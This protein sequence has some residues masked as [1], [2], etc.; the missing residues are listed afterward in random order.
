MR[1]VGVLRVQCHWAAVLGDRDS[2]RDAGVAR[3]DVAEQ[4]LEPLD[5]VVAEVAADADDHPLRPVP[6]VEVGEERIARCGADGLLAAEDLP[7]ERLVPV[8]QRLVDRADVV[9]RRVDAH[10]HLLDDDALLALDLLR[11]EAR[12][13][14]HVDEHVE[15]DVAVLC[16]AADVVA[17]QLL[18]GERVEL[19]ADAVDLAGDLARGRAA[20]GALEE[21]VL[22]EVRDPARLGGLV[23]GAGCVEE[24][25]RDRLC[26]R[27]R[28]RQDADPVR[29]RVSLEDPHRAR[30]V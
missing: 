16:G 27:H 6:A 25:A 28:R 20:L 8:E 15:G 10:P 30:M 24:Q 5:Q 9:A 7:A 14:Q 29:E 19:A 22:G 23:A 2:R 12:V 26:V 17:G 18:A 21:H 3:L 11:V 4:L 1:L 13:A